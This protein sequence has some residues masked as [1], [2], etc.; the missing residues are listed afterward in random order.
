MALL[1]FVTLFNICLEVIKYSSPA[2]EFIPHIR[3]IVSSAY[4][5]DPEI[6]TLLNTEFSPSASTYCQDLFKIT[7]SRWLDI[8]L[9]YY[10]IV[11]L[12]D[13]LANNL[14]QLFYVFAFIMLSWVAIG[15]QFKD[16][17]DKEQKMTQ[18]DKL[19]TLIYQGAWGSR[20]V[21]TL[22]T[23]L[24]CILGALLD[25]VTAGAGF[26]VKSWIL[27][28]ASTYLCHVVFLKDTM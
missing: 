22:A 21:V 6:Q 13:L 5:F 24:Y 26:L 27:I 9:M 25:L 10:F 8:L 28:L 7:F 14:I 18:Q 1:L 20:T 3:L 19:L 11:R 23:I 12:G 2:E 16:F 4:N 17:D 15:F